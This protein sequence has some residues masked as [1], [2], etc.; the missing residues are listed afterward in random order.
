MHAVRNLWLDG[1][2]ATML[3]PNL[4]LFSCINVYHNDYRLCSLYNH[5][6]SCSDFTLLQCH[7]MLIIIL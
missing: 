2:T 7:G 1:K 3:M 5:S 4:H 6:G